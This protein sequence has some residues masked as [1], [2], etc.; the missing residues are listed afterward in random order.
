MQKR[1][2]PTQLVKGSRGFNEFRWPSRLGL[3]ED[4][5]SK[6]KR[7][8]VRQP[9]SFTAPRYSTSGSPGPRGHL[10]FGPPRFNL[11]RRRAVSYL[12]NENTNV[13][14]R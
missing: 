4:G 11:E 9:T 12:V 8:G 7:P 10:E 3:A 13:N 2:S 5:M 14:K 6:A 1:I